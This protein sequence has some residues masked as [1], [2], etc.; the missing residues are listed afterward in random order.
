[1]GITF[2]NNDNNNNNNL[3]E[4]F[5]KEI[6]PSVNNGFCEWSDY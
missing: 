6:H 2:C 1:M 4:K 5:W 3:T